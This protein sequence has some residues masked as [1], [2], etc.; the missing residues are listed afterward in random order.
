MEGGNVGLRAQEAGLRSR[1]LHACVSGD[2]VAEL[3]L[4]TDEHDAFNDRE[5]LIGE[6]S[7]TPVLDLPFHS[8][9]GRPH[10]SLCGK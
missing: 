8:S 1:R 4:Q 6:K 5:R 9:V 10:H 2:L 3:P 7:R